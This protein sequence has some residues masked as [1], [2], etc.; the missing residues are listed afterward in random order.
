[1]GLDIGW[2][3]FFK[4]VRLTKILKFKKIIGIFSFGKGTTLNYYYKLNLALFNLLILMLIS[5]VLLHLGACL[6]CA[7]GLRSALIPGTWVY[8][9]G[10]QNT[11][12]AEIYLTALYFCLSVLTTVG[13]GDV[14]AFTNHEILF[15]IF[16]MQFGVAFYSLTIGIISSFFQDKETKQSLVT[17]RIKK[18]ESLCYTMD[19]DYDLEKKM[20]VALSYSGDKISYQW[21]SSRL[22]IFGDLP[23]DVQHKL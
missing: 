14:H 10:L 4:A 2:A 12:H 8:Q 6:W 15:C 11:S 9:L 1:M 16:W 17:N 3:S 22:D 5:M 20:K 23:V 19:I 21:L 18:L 13:Y 7:L